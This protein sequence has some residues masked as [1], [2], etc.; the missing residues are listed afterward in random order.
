[1]AKKNKK[2]LVP[3]IV[4]LAKLPGPTSF[5][6]LWSIKHALN[7]EK[8]GHTGTLDSFAEG[9]LV[10]LSGKLTHLVPHVT[11][12]TKTYKAVVCF[13]RGTVT[14]DPTVPCT[15]FGR[16]VTKKEVE[17]VIP[18]FT[19]ALLQKPPVY[20]ALR[21]DGI[22]ASDAVRDGSEVKLESRE[23]FVYENKLIDFKEDDGSGVS[24][25]LLEIKCSKG[26]YIR[27]IARDMAKALGT[28]SY[29]CALRRTE[30]GPFSLNEAACASELKDF[31]I[32]YGI[33]NA[34]YFES[35]KDSK[36]Q[37]IE[38][39]P[40]MYASIRSHL[41]RFT[42]EVAYS[43]GF[44]SDILKKEAERLYA[45]GR[46][47]LWK[48]FSRIQELEEKPKNEWRCETSFAVYYSDMQFAGM[49][50]IVNSKP[51]YGFVV[52]HAKKEF[53]VYDWTD[54]LKGE[55]PLQWKNKGTSLTIGS[56]DGLHAGHDALFESTLSYAKEKSLVPGVV[57]F[58][59]S[60]KT[61][62][63]LFKGQI[64][65]LSQK[66]DFLKN[67]GFSFVLVIDFSPEF[68]KMEGTSFVHFIREALGLS[69]LA[70]GEDFRCGYKGLLTMKELSLVAK[71]ENFILQTVEDVVLDGKRVSS[72]RVRESVF[73]AEFLNVQKMLLRPFSFDCSGFEWQKER[74]DKDGVWLVSNR[75]SAQVLPKE[76]IYNVVAILS[77][78]E[79]FEDSV[80][81]KEVSCNTLHT[82]FSVEKDFIKI[83]LATEGM[84]K[85][86]QAINFL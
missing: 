10:V 28:V 42:P 68:S 48:H 9:L 54:V 74:E 6:S 44:S 73:N 83:L 30:V 2:P 65:T 86:V 38:D 75:L 79:A 56:F 15:V 11:G 60:C 20:S 21:V 61:N 55:F 27:A 36:P 63:P 69:Y 1:M 41:L 72:S 16:A 4:P 49:M 14:L 82:L 40:E 67:K 50:N 80:E 23:I 45:N 57:T 52:P 33:R 71:D 39:T 66:L 22:R 29:L 31:T 77:G 24:Y 3:G 76:G 34:S 46:P 13:G 51:K 84:A 78:D 35:L 47:L 7:T 37:K 26:T 43:C 32:E 18:K 62:D 85:R 17:E 19:G 64:T 58:T 70:E 5:S 81:L 25:A 8:V 12:F 53:K 59:R